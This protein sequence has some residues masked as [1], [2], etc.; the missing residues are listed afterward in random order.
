MFR[1]SAVR[2]SRPGPQRVHASSTQSTAHSH[3]TV[4][5][6][7][8]VTITRSSPWTW[9]S[10]V[11]TCRSVLQLMIKLFLCICWWLVFLY[12]IAH[13]EHIKFENSNSSLLNS[14]GRFPLVCNNCGCSFLLTVRHT[15][16]NVFEDIL[17]RKK[18]GIRRYE[19]WYNNIN[20]SS[21][22]LCRRYEGE[23]IPIPKH[24]NM[25]TLGSVEVK[26]HT[27]LPRLEVVVPGK[28]SALVAL[29]PNSILTLSLSLYIYIYI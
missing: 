8:S 11:E 13:M 22:L 20:L 6:N 10:R 14:N 2:A 26:L 16:L 29:P 19:N 15:F 24:F 18:K 25:E 3:S 12:N 21:H 5:C 1:L 7:L 4:K 23:L 27:L 17:N 28:L 9:P